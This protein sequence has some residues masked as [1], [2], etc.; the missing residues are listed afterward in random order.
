[1]ARLLGLGARILVPEHTVAARIEAIAGEGAEVEVVRGSYDDAVELSAA[2]A[3]DEHLV[4]SDTS[5]PGYE[6]VPGWV[7]D[8]YT[9]IFAE[10]AEQQAEVPPLVAVQIGVGALASAAVRALAA[11]GRV[12]VGVEPAGAACAL[13]AVRGGARRC[14]SRGRTDRHGRPRLRPGLAGRA[15]RHGARHRRLLRNRRPRRRDRGAAAAARRPRVRR[16]RRVRRRRAD[17]AARGAGD[18]AWARLG[19]AAPPAALA[20]CTEAPTDPESFARITG[21]G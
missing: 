13:A 20:I 1:M 15:A 21:A 14:S 3:D 19:L 12:L 9:T 11:P 2:A 17:R 8:G 16:D 6:E 18:D 7:A 10:L 5:W 4:I